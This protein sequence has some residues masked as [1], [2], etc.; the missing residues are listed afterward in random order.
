MVD[1]CLCWL[2]R[3]RGHDGFIK[4]YKILINMHKIL[5]RPPLD[6]H[7]TGGRVGVFSHGPVGA[8]DD[9]FILTNIHGGLLGY[10]PPPA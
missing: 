1:C 3:T 7:G 10:T 5:H 4:I 6:L 2:T 9:D 8:Q